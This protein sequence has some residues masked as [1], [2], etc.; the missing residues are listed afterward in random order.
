MVKGE[1]PKMKIILLYMLLFLFLFFIG[2][3]LILCYIVSEKM[4]WKLIKE[5]YYCLWK[6]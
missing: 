1:Q 4:T 5:F 3:P 2:I 6:N